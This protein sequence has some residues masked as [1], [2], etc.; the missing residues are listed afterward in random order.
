MIK[1][2]LCMIYT[3]RLVHHNFPGKSDLIIVDFHNSIEVKHVCKHSLEYQ[4][5]IN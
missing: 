2:F 5:V 3:I 4:I 1:R